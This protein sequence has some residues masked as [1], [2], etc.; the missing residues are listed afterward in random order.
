MSSSDIQAALIEADAADADGVCASQTPSG[1]GDLA[2]NGALASA[3]AVTF[4]VPRQVTISGTG[5]ESGK[6]FT[7][8]GTDETGAVSSESIAGPNN[9]TVSTTKYFATVTQVSVDAA[10]AAAVT[11]GSGGDVAVLIFNGPIRLRGMYVLNSGSSG[12][13]TFRE[14]SATGNVRMQ[15]RTSGAATSTE[16][17]SLPDYGIRHDARAYVLFDQTTMTS[18]TVFYS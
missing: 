9:N 4:D 18:M 13:V 10:T 5:S 15:Y 6:T 1:A 11:V 2:I 7:I 16:Y 3:G 12:L 17:P 14:G 8:T